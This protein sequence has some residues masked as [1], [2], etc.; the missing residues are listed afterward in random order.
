MEAELKYE[1]LSKL[2]ILP[3]GKCISVP[4]IQNAVNGENIGIEYA[5]LICKVLGKT[6]DELFNN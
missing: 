4:T 3:N 5:K 1:E 6:L 2:C